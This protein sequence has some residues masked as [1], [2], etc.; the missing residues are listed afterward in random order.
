M[1][2]VH[3][4]LRA[5]LLAAV[6]A[7]VVAAGAG[8]AAAQEDKDCSDFSTQEEAQKYFESRGGPEQDPDMLDP[9]HDGKACEGLPS[10]SPAPAASPTPTPRPGA[11]QLPNNGAFSGIM[12][13]SGLSFLEAGVALSLLAARVKSRRRVP[14]SVL[15]SL[16]SAAKE[17]R[18]EVALSDDVFIVRRSASERPWVDEDRAPV[19]VDGITG[20]PVYIA[21]LA[22]AVDPPEES[23]DM[24]V[25]PPESE[26]DWPYFTPPGV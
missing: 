9:D 5:G 7:A 4:Y 17:G 13:L 26:D 2:H 21:A 22:E 3:V 11:Q 10:G 25:V 12:A 6:S 1:R 15:K 20:G 18:N 14:L 8:S 16:A 19:P 23:Q 24:E